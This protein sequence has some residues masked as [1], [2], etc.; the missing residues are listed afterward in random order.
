MNISHF[1]G[2]RKSSQ[3]WHIFRN[4]GKANTTFIEI[5]EEADRGYGGHLAGAEVKVK[6]ELNLDLIRK[7]WMLT[8]DSVLSPSQEVLM[9]LS[10]F[11]SL[12]FAM[13]ASL[14]SAQPVEAKSLRGVFH[15]EFQVTTKPT[16]KL[17]SMWKKFL[18]EKKNKQAKLRLG[19]VRFCRSKQARPEPLADHKKR[20]ALHQRESRMV[21]LDLRM[22]RLQ[23][24]IAALKSAYKK[25]KYEQKV[26]QIGYIVSDALFT[27]GSYGLSKTLQVPWL[28]VV[29]PVSMKLTTQM[30]SNPNKLPQPSPFQLQLNQD[31]ARLLQVIQFRLNPGPFQNTACYLSRPKLRN[32]AGSRCH[33]DHP[34]IR[35]RHK[36]LGLLWSKS[37]KLMKSDD[38]PAFWSAVFEF[39]TRRRKKVLQNQEFFILASSSLLKLQ[40]QFLKKM[41]T[42][43]HN[44]Y[45]AWGCQQLQS[46]QRKKKR[47][48]RISL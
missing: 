10:I 13:V 17:R 18:Q 36:Q 31:M 15:P 6:F 45:H 42:V 8:I 22:K 38:L 33:P 20:L 48:K 11:T 25:N 4:G 21:A 3:F 32:K 9:R 40:I 41:N 28:Q 12:C 7:D 1:Q 39:L 43:L 26:S 34:F 5:K 29:M 24:Y 47:T 37:Q 30:I 2:F 16:A 27:L 19:L 44:D 23:Q 35:S 46:I 14:W